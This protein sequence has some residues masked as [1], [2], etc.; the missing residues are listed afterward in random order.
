MNALLPVAWT[1]GYIEIIVILAIALL[2]FGRKLPGL[3]RDVGT[4]IREFKDGL[5]GKPEKKDA[6]SETEKPNETGSNDDAK[7]DD[8]K[9]A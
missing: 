9:K 3:G 7:N 8:S 1:P 2:L 6:K 4:G 5:E